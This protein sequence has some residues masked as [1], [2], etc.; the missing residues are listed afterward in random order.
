MSEPIIH[1]PLGEPVEAAHE[2]IHVLTAFMVLVDETGKAYAVLQV[3]DGVEAA[4]QPDSTSVRRA[5][6]EIVDDIN[7][8]AAA[9]YAAGEVYVA[10]EELK[11]NEQ[12]PP[13]AAVKKAFKKRGK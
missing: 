2:H 8:L 5:C 1:P 10:L 7:A 3:P 9:R 6:S 11:K 12:E 4:Y 13:S